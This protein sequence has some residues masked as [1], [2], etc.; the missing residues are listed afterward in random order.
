MRAL[1]DAV[2]RWRTPKPQPPRQEEEEAL[3]VLCGSD[4]F[5]MESY[6]TLG[7]CSSCN[8]HHAIS[9]WQRIKILAD[10]DS[11]REI[12]ASI[13][14]IDPLSF[15]EGGDYRDSLR[16]AFR[17]TRLR[18]AAIT[19]VCKI[20]G[21]P[22]VLIILDFG[23]LGGSLGVVVGERVAQ[24][25][26]YASDRELPVVSVITSSGTRLQ[27]GVLALMQMAK[28]AAAAGQ[29]SRRRLTHVTILG[30]PSTGGGFAS[31]ANLADMIIGEPGALMGHVPL[32]DVE[33]AE[34]GELPPETHTAESHLAHGL[35]DQVVERRR[36][37]DL[38]AS[39]L[40]LTAPRPRL[41][42]KR[43]LRPLDW[44]PSRATN[45]WQEV[46]LARQEGRPGALDYIGRIADTFV[47]LRGDRAAD[48]DPKVITGLA[49]LGGQAV[50]LIGQERS[51]SETRQA[52]L[53]RP[54]GLRKSLRAM[55]VAQKFRLP[56]VTLVDSQGADP[57]REAEEHGLG[58]AIAENLAM[59]AGIRT[60]VIAAIIGEG[61]G[62]GALALA[63]ADRVLM[64]EHAI[65]SVASPERAA[66]VFYRDQSRAERLAKALRLTAADALEL[67]VVDRVVREPRGGAHEDHDAAAAQL[68]SAI[69]EALTEISN[70]PVS[71]LVRQRYQRYRKIGI[72]QSFFQ[73]SLRRNLADMQNDVRERFSQALRRRMHGP[74]NR[75]EET[76]GIAFD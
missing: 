5:G 52:P 36:Q 69:R 62:S 59:L 70:V 76:P 37:P 51:R 34:G 7:V 2:A 24:A 31:F 21:R 74:R 56:L 20:Q 39:I 67:G 15:P 54:E 71:K 75:D 16:E 55:R 50:V 1:A 26:E 42:V 38:V 41:R 17:R 72:Y 58:H 73:V 35:I 48:D 4:T 68:A 63:V 66:A 23:F 3:C 9:A 40:A 61:A 27:E 43:G 53:I 13:T 47:E 46:Q 14:S 28:T 57:G 60:P 32:R 49:D 44:H 22:T 10:G 18:E 45:P 30:N 25:F 12:H 65:F 8:Y 64:L 33:E 11:F 19:G 29:H 6:A